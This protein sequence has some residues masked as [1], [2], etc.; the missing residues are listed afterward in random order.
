MDSMPS[1]GRR[2]TINRCATFVR[3]WSG[4]APGLPLGWVGV[5][6]LADLG[7][8]AGVGVGGA[9]LSD[10]SGVLG[11]RLP[12]ADSTVHVI[13]QDHKDRLDLA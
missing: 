8:L 3:L 12:E 9:A 11:A 1:L 6:G 5:P 13:R 2:T 7:A 10:F 4:S